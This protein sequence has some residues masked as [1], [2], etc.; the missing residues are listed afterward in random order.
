MAEDFLNLFQG[1]ALHREMGGAGMPQ[2]VKPKVSHARTFHSFLKRRA[3][4]TPV[5]SIR[6]REHPAD[7]FLRG[8]L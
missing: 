6:S 8:W 5:L 1:T 7:P 3:N 4:L 2:I